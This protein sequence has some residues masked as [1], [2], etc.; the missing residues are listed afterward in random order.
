MSLFSILLFIYPLDLTFSFNS[1]FHTIFIIVDIVL[2]GY[3]LKEG[4]KFSSSKVWV[5]ASLQLILFIIAESILVGNSTDLIVDELSCFMFTVI[6]IVGSLIIVFAL[7][8]INKE[9]MSEIRKKTFLVYLCLFLVV[10]NLIV[11]TNSLMIFFLLFE[12]TTLASYLLIGFRKDEI[13]QKNALKALWMNQIGG[14]LIL[15]SVIFSSFQDIPAY[16]TNMIESPT[17]LLAL[18]LLALA[19]LIKGA[20][21][22][23]DSWLLGAMVAPTPV[24][25]ILHSATMVKIAPFVILKLSSSLENTIAGD[26]IIFFGSF[27]F[28]IAALYGLSREKFKEILGYSTISLLGLMCAMAVCLGTTD[29]TVVYILIF[30]HAVSKALLF[31]LAGILEKKYHIKEVWQMD[32]LLHKAPLSASMIIFGFASITLP[33]FGLFFG[34]LFSIEISTQMLEK[35]PAYLALLIALA[36]G[37]AILTLLYFKVASLLFSKQAVQ[38][39]FNKE[40]K[41]DIAMLVPYIY[42]IILIASVWFILKIGIQIPLIYVFLSLLMI[43]LV[44]ICLKLFPFKNVDRVKEYYCA[45]QEHFSV[46]Q[47]S[48]EISQNNQKFITSIGIFLFFAVAFAGGVL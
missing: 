4:F 9:D 29:P 6:N 44:P 48:F 24:S 16:F 43:I 45:E 27:V 7:W 38:E 19:A 23:F 25:A 42:T 8:Y 41:W 14:I 15:L 31:L 13:G 39:S 33:P 37:S 22:P 36:L 5:L 32:G 11:I 2:I 34:K 18:S 10:M 12:M 30:F 20:Q 1:F 21:T 28:L 35:G 26:I 3:F 47:W 17:L 40:N 46:G